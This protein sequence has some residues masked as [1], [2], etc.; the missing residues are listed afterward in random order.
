MSELHVMVLTCGDLGYEVAGQLVGVPGVAR[1]TL[2]TAPYRQP[3]RTFTGKLKHVWRTQGAA[4]FWRIAAARFGR[5]DMAHDESP[6]LPAGVQHLDVPEFHDAAALEQLRALAP[7]LGVVAGT[8]I[9]K[10]SLFGIPRL[11]SINLH[12]GKAPEYRGAAPAF[13][14][15][16]NGE[17]EV[18]ITI[19]RVTAALDAG[20]ILRQECFPLDTAPSEDPVEYL[21]R[22]RREVL[23]PNGVRL[24]RAAVAD[25]AAGAVK[26]TPQDM[27]KARTY[28]SPDRAAMKEL[29]R[30][31]AGR[32]KRR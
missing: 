20:H 32:R 26:E 31:V 7:D 29:R 13:W 5:P 28:R 25:I 21:D 2:V 12:S 22:F 27:S 9:L 8:Y 24:M 18:G 16:H 17:P 19:H 23:R 14:E 1:V 6:P 3:R 30:R 15:L 10:E 11:G 4:G